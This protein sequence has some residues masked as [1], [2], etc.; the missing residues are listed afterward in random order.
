M[1]LKKLKYA[2]DYC[3]SNLASFTLI[4][5][6]IF[7]LNMTNANVPKYQGKIHWILITTAVILGLIFHGYGLVVTKDN[8]NNGKS[9]PKVPFYRSFVFGVKSAV[10]VAI[11]GTIQYFLYFFVSVTF[12]YPFIE[13]GEGKIAVSHLNA[14]FYAHGGLDTILFVIFIII[15]TYTFIFF[16][17]I[18]LARL[19][20]KGSL[21]SSLNII[22]IGKCISTIGW[23]HYAVDYTKLIISIGILAYIQYGL[24]FIV[25]HPIINLFIGLIM[26]IIQYI[27]IGRIYRTYLDK[28]YGKTFNRP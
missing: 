12:N 4:L 5:I 7:L 16:M 20:D 24:N 17:E 21:I 13:M 1:P 14:L 15:S 8:I 11:Y 18:A 19:A 25:T 6:M 28:K 26:F 27:G 23:V 22:T 3:R 9:L 2:Y 10:I